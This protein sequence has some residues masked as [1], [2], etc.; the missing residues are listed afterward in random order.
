MAGA[1]TQRVRGTWTLGLGDSMLVKLEYGT[2]GDSKR[3]KHA[4]SDNGE[5]NVQNTRNISKIQLRKACR[6]PFRHNTKE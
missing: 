3:Q 2:E 1:D 5:R 6:E 4:F